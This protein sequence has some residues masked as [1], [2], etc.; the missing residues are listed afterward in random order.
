[1]SRAAPPPPGPEGAVPPMWLL[2]FGAAVLAA[3]AFSVAPVRVLGGAFMVLGAAALVSPAS[4]ANL[5]LALGFGG[6]NLGFGAL[7]ARRHGG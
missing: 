1:M 5:H 3:G 7:I 6:L 4:W 2:L